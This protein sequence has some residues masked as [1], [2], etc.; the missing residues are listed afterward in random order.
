MR[1]TLEQ[2]GGFAGLMITKSIDT[3]DLSPS[4]AQ[5]LENLVK[6]SN[7]FQLNSIVEASPQPD[8]FGYTLMIEMNGRSHSIDLSETNMPEKVRPIADWVQTR[9]R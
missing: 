2:S 3:Q 4:E 6:S 8:R 5:Q 9:S 7:F 1:V